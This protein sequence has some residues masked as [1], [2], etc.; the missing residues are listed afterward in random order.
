MG[1]FKS[2]NADVE[3]AKALAPLLSSL[4]GGKGRL[5]HRLEALAQVLAAANI[6]GTGWSTMEVDWKIVDGETVPFMKL[7]A[8]DGSQITK[9]G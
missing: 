5:A 2:E 8:I 6:T 7:T 4:S 1:M 9:E 3:M